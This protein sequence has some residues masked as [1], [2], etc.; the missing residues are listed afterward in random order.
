VPKGAHPLPGE[1]IKK[2][3]L[4]LEAGTI[5]HSRAI[6]FL[7]SLGVNTVQVR[8]APPGGIAGNRKR[9]GN[10]RKKIKAWANL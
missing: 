5:V 4:V 10:T 6:G 2:G 8:P 3:K 9:A 7:A 1:G